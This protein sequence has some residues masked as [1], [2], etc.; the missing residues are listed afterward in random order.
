ML[1]LLRAQ[2]ILR[3]SPTLKSASAEQRGITLQL[4]ATWGRKQEHI[5][6]ACPTWPHVLSDS[7]VHWCQ[8]FKFDT[9]ITRQSVL[10]HG[11]QQFVDRIC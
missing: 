3:V 11:G 2:D 8:H 9:A 10:L 5:V 7:V 4:F 1:L 6:A